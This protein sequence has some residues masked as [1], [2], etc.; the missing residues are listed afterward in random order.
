MKKQYENKEIRNYMLDLLIT[1]CTHSEKTL[2]IQALQSLM[3]VVKSLYPYFNEYIQV[4]FRVLCPL[5]SDPD[6]E[7]SVPSIEFWNTVAQEDN[8]RTSSP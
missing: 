5:L 2:K 7:V 1:T 4:I 6:E 3:D 8:E